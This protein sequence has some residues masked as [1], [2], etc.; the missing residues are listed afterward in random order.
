MRKILL[1]ML[2]IICI[3]QNSIEG[4]TSQ[5][6]FLSWSN[7]Q[8]LLAIVRVDGAIELFD[9]LSRDTI[10]VTTSLYDSPGTITWSPDNQY[11]AGDYT[12]DIVRI[13]DVNTGFLLHEFDIFGGSLGMIWSSDNKLYVSTIE[14]GTYIWDMNTYEFEGL[15]P[16]SAYTF[17]FSPDGQ[18][19]AIGGR[20]GFGIYDILSE[21][22]SDIQQYPEI[23]HSLMWNTDGTKVAGID[24]LGNFS[25]WDLTTNQLEISLQMA[26]G[27][28]MWWEANHLYV[29][30]DDVINIWDTTTWQIISSVPLGVDFFVARNSIGSLYAEFK[31]TEFEIATYCEIIPSDDTLALSNAILDGNSIQ[32]HKQI[33]LTENATYTLTATL[34]SITGEVTLIGNGATINMT[35]GAQIFNVAE[36][37]A[38]TLKNVTLSGGNSEQGGAIFNAGDLNLENVILENNSAVRGGAIYNAGN[39]V[40]NGGAIQ[41]NSATEFGGG[42]YN[43]GEMSLDGVNIR[44]NDA[45]EGSGVYQGE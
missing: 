32:F 18:Y 19:L 20:G 38:L 8:S 29:A 27:V 35:G 12:D 24:L 33:C 16:Y 10:S 39:L 23:A 36:T 26:P 41:N 6:W 45:P 1:V 37:G 25:I 3:S 43:T 30:N 5:I 15:L 22:Y 17:S 4:Q 34:P 28:L 11:I 9:T 40:M 44:E 2:F 31:G 42:I 7:D 14:L 13:W 21:N